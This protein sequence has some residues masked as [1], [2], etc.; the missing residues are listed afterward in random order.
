MGFLIRLII[1][2]LALWLTVFL[3]R[4]LGL[5]LHIGAGANGAV[6]ALI[7]VIVLAVVNATIGLIVRLIT[8]P[9]NCLTLGLLSFVINALM[10]WLVGSLGIP[11]FRVGSFVAGLFG[12]V[13]MTIISSVLTTMTGDGREGGD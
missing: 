11:G 4:Q 6:T 5:D 8:A 9:L 3:G 1:N 7:V 13:V 2:A 10:F 12:S